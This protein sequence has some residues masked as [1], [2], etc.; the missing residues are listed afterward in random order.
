MNKNVE[1]SLFRLIK[2]KFFTPKKESKAKKEEENNENEIEI[3][4]KKFILL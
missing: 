3:I 1:Y 4:L 2:N